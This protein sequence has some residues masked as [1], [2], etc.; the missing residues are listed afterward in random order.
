MTG[1]GSTCFGIVKSL[2]DIPNL[3]KFIN[4]K[5]FVWFGQKAD[6]NLNRVSFSKV[7]ENKF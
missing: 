2:K 4:N 5:Y 6:F 7:L 3:D 1:S